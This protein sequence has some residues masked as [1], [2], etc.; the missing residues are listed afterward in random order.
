MDTN[1]N[2]K[3]EIQAR[4]RM[5]EVL[6]LAGAGG[7]VD[8]ELSGVLFNGAS[9]RGVF[10][11][12]FPQQGAPQ[13]SRVIP[14]P[15]TA[16]SVLTIESV[17]AES[18][19]LVVFNAAGREVTRRRVNA[20]PSKVGAIVDLSSLRELT[21]LAS[22]IYFYRALARGRSSTGRFVILR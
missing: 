12:A 5:S 4:F 3:P 17:S 7:N 13:V 20:S 22:G 6:E 8:L 9:L 1:G 19:E 11:V 10:T 14:N 18:I 16:E 21:A 2:A 15:L